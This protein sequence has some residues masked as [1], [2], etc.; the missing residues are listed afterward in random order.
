MVFEQAKALI[1][2]C[3]IVQNKQAGVT[4]K[5]EGNPII[6]R[7]AIYEGNVGILLL[8]KGQ[9][10][11]EQCQIYGNT[12]AGVEVRQHGKALIRESRIY[13]HRNHNII[14]IF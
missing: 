3:Q 14:M 11:I 13:G 12:S 2:G 4:I 5:E 1:E 7:S 9:G 10:T 8:Q 6:R